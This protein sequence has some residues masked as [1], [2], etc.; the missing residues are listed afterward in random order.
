MY[1]DLKQHF[2]WNAMKKEITQYVV[3]C[4]MCQQVKAK[5]QRLARLLQP[6]PI[7]E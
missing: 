4:L 5:H 2:W 3:K 1:Q 7:P 6:L